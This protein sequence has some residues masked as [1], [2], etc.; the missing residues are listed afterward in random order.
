MKYKTKTKIM[1]FH[2]YAMIKSRLLTA[3]SKSTSS[4]HE[5]EKIGL[6]SNS[7]HAVDRH[8]SK[9]QQTLNRATDNAS[10]PPWTD[11]QLSGRKL[12]SQPASELP[13]PN[14]LPCSSLSHQQPI[15]DLS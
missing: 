7:M 12:Y 9:S 13:T 2:V 11:S 8:Y 5:K 10:N 15:A 1:S 6:A 4:D 3:C 14:R